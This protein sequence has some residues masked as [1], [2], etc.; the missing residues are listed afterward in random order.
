MPITSTS[1]IAGVAVPSGSRIT[2]WKIYSCECQYTQLG[3]GEMEYVPSP[4]VPPDEPVTP[5]KAIAEYIADVVS[6]ILLTLP[7]FLS[8]FAVQGINLLQA[9]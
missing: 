1:I 3:K 8:W 4:E 2:G 6:V 5:Q 9:E 7:Q